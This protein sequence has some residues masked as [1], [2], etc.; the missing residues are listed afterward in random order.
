M[1]IAG[2]IA[3]ALLARARTGETSVLDISLLSVGLWANALAVD[4]SLANG[5]AWPGGSM[6]NPPEARTN[7]GAGPVRTSDGRYLYLAMIQV[8]KFWAD[9]CRHLGREDMID[10]D[11]WNTPEKLLENAPAAA[12]IVHEV[13]GSKP[14]AHWVETFRSLEGQWAPVQDSLELGQDP[15]ARANGL[16]AE[17]VDADGTTRELVTN[18]VQFDELP[19]A[20]RRAPT[21][22]EHT[23][24]LLRELGFDD[25][26][27]LELKISGAVT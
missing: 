18:P 9:F 21:F 17:I 6:G 15:Q 12:K 14:Y 16:I 26:R 1:T 3:A 2:G 13:I 25:E 22:A 27:L 19:V 5:E 24:E 11:R 23:D 20:L 4:I 7:P 10:D 8:S